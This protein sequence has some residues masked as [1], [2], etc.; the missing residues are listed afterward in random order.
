LDFSRKAREGAKALG[1]YLNYLSVLSFSAVKKS[2]RLL[3]VHRCF[4]VGFFTQGSRRSKDAGRVFELSL[5][6]LVLCGKK[7]FVF[8]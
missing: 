7:I 3:S 1:E 8:T 2:S 5:R 4:A 6:S